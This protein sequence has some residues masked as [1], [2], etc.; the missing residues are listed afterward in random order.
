MSAYLE[1]FKDIFEKT[2][3]VT[4]KMIPSKVWLLADVHG[5]STTAVEG[6]TLTTL[7]AY[8]F[9]KAQEASARASPV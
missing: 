6:T 5:R 8:D 1:K 3:R 2:Y 9:E 7:P 4:L